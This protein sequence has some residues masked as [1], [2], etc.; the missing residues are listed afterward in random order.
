MVDRGA[1][2]GLEDA[3]R[4]ATR[5]FADA[6]SGGDPATAAVGYAENARLVAPSATV[7]EGR[8]GI[9]SF[10]RAGLEAG[11]RAVE[12]E[13]VRIDRHGAFGVEIGHYSMRLHQ[14]GGG[15]VVDRGSYLRVHE[16]TPGG[17]WAWAIEAFTPDGSPQ[18][19]A[20]SPADRGEVRDE[21]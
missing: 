7:F 17:G 3:A 15:D 14:P 13:S 18:V 1:A 9:E 2:D 11:I 19:A 21:A 4:V 8:A 10:W 6:I 5:R 16:L 12:L 20:P